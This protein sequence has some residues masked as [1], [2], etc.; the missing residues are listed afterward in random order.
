MTEKSLGSAEDLMP[1]EPGRTHEELTPRWL[2]S[3]ALGTSDIPR[4][5]SRGVGLR[6]YLF[7]FIPQL[8]SDCT[9]V[10]V[11]QGLS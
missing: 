9:E 7:T 1:E 11:N 10:S 6:V 8:S 5:G 2:L 3:R 4:E